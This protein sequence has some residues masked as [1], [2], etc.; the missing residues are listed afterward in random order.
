MHDKIQK[1]L[2]MAWKK[3]LPLTEL[4][5]YQKKTLYCSACIAAIWFVIERFGKQIFFVH[6]ICMR[7]WV[8]DDRKGL[9]LRV[10]VRDDRKGLA[11]GV[12]Q[13]CTN[14][15]KRECNDCILL[16]FMPRVTLKFDVFLL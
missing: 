14:V 15:V 4:L 11:R 9:A 10:W 7:V 6:N 1:L 2:Y 16:P 12:V 8:R 5:G 13:R 3:G